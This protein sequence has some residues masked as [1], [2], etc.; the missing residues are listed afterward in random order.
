VIDALHARGKKAVFHSDGDLNSVLDDLVDSGIDGLNP[1]EI[2][3]GMDLADLHRR[4]PRLLFFGGIDVSA[5]LPFGSP[6]EVRDAVVKAIDDTEG[7][8]LVGSSTE[9]T[10]AVPLENYLA[11]RGAATNYR[12]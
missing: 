2:A 9:V 12:F 11:L 10:N 6:D 5:L 1:I 3:A 7:R 8:I 4:Y